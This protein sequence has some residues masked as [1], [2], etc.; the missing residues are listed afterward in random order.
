MHS[1][2]DIYAAPPAT[3]EFKDDVGAVGQIYNSRSTNDPTGGSKIQPIF[4]KADLSGAGSLTLPI[5]AGDN[6]ASN[7]VQILDPPPPGE[8]PSSPLAQARLYNNAMLIVSNSASGNVIV[9]TGPWNNFSNVAP[10]VTN[11]ATGTTSYSFVTNV[12]FYDYRENKQVRATQVDVSKLRA[13][14]NNNS[15]GGG[16]ALNAIAQLELNHGLN[17]VYVMNQ[18]TNGGLAAVRVANGAQLPDGGLTVGTPLPLYVDGNYNLNNGDTTAGQTATSQTQPAALIGDA[19]TILSTT[20]SD[21]FNSSKT[22]SSMPGAGNTTVNAAILTGIVESTKDASGNP[23]YSGGV[24]NLP[25]LLEN[26][27][28]QNTHLQRLN[29]GYVSQPL[30]N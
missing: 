4:D 20:W 23:H 2:G 12:T 13:W 16:S 15:A 17:S 26:W 1:N 14:L 27:S 9:K 11:T 21:S 3:L 6:S 22:R 8:D 25:R 18:Q 30:R 24:E 28:G 10:D 7:V 19:I 29:G 5:G